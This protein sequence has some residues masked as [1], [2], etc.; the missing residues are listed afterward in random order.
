MHPLSRRA[1]LASAASPLLARG[2]NL[3]IGVM[4]GICGKATDPAAVEIA[5]RLGFEGLQVTLGKPPAAGRMVMADP[6][7]QALLL[8]ESKKHKL[9]LVATYI[10]VLHV[11]CLKNDREAVKW[12]VEGIDITRR[13]NAPILMLPF[14]FK[15]AL[16]NSAD[17]DS[18]VGPLRE[19]APEAEKAGVTLGFENTIT[20]EDDL[21]ILERINSKALKIYYDIGNAT[22][23][24][25]VDPTREIRTLKNHIC[26]FHFKD[27]GYLGAGD[28]DVRA[29]LAAIR[30]I[31]WK[32]HIVLETSAPSREIE[33]D[34]RRNRE[35]LA[36]LL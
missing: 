26:Q 35:Y 20:A 7:R 5:A 24:Y 27:K 19:L 32:G 9:P 16:E 3:K 34:L 21:R 14:F 2:S 17:M 11:N 36:R 23:L 15:C 18:V 22:N 6:D 28:V 29:A 33:G 12:T 30:S 1:F 13:L 8:A 4:D 31:E 10:D 25:K